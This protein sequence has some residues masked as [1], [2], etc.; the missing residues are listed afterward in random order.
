MR[1]INYLNAA[2]V[3]TDSMRFVIGWCELGGAR[4]GWLVVNML[5]L[6]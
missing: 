4:S 2:S 3:E 1:N 5:D 6:C